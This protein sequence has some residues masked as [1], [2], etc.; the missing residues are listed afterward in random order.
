MK[1]SRIC[2]RYEGKEAEDMRFPK[3]YGALQCVAALALIAVLLVSVGV[4]TER[5][6]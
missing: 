2:E 3:N 4:A 1:D 6:V 5:C